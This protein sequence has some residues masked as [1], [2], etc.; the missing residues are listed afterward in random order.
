MRRYAGISAIA[1]T[2]AL[3]GAVVL[4]TVD[5]SAATNRYEAES[6]PAVCGGAVASNHSGYSGSGFCDTTNALGSA[7]QFTVSTPGPVTA[8]L[9][10]RYA[11]GGGTGRPADVSVNGTVAQGGLPFELTGAWTTWATKTLTVR[12]AAGSNTVRLAATTSDGLANID[13]LDV[14]LDD[15]NPTTPA[16]RPPR[17]PAGRRSAP[18]PRRSAATSRSPRQLHGDR[19][20][21]RPRRGG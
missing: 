1:M 3:T 19:V 10:I 20:D 5:A 2:V 7:V 4:S 15:A 11:N 14:T 17:R 21:R 12:L 13:H 16:R 8:V 18:A 6:P 9:S